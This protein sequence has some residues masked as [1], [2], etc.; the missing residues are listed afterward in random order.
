MRPARGPGLEL[1]L[2]VMLDRKGKCPSRC[3]R[4]RKRL[5]QLRRRPLR[6]STPSPGGI[7]DGKPPLPGLL[8]KGRYVLPLRIPTLRTFPIP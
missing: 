3:S 7:G 2:L 6:S 1:A 8:E 4:A 5:R